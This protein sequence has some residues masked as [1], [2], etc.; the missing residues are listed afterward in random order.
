MLV[1]VRCFTCNKVIGHLWEPYQQK[2][3]ERYQQTQ[4]NTPLS[5]KVSSLKFTE[6]TVRDVENKTVQGKIL[7][8]L[9]VKKYCC[10]SIL[11]S[12]IDLTTK[13]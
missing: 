11:I 9:N 4:E 6:A 8:E 13:I 1:P 7:D 2:L 10:R 5:Q 12:T 3:Q